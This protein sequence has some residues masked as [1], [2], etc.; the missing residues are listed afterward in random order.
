HHVAGWLLSELFSAGGT[1]V[2]IKVTPGASG[3]LQLYLDDDLVYDKKSEGNLTP[4]LTR[5]KE[6]KTL[7]KQ[8]IEAAKA[9]IPA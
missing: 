2:A 9:K 8:R 6:L 4:S 1:D 5:V 3:I 7:L